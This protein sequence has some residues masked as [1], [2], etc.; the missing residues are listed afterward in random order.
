[1]DINFVPRSVAHNGCA[2]EKGKNILGMLYGPVAFVWSIEPMIFIT[3]SVDVGVIKNDCLQ[4]FPIKSLNDLLVGGSLDLILPAIY[5]KKLL[6]DS[7]IAFWSDARCPSISRESLDALF[8][9]FKE[10]I[11]LIPIQICLEFFM[12]S[13]RNFL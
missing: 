1:M 2:V 13:L 8:F 12:L 3:S 10:I 6:S 5:V 7:A 11:S 9:D 4:G